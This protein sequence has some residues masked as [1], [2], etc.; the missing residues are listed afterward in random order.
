MFS[1]HFVSL[2]EEMSLRV[3]IQLF[4]IGFTMEISLN[5]FLNLEIKP[6]YKKKKQKKGITFSTESTALVLIAQSP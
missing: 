6:F 5:P 4:T 2:T 1:F 3:R